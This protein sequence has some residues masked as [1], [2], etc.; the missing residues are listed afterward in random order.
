MRHHHADINTTTL[1]VSFM[2][3]TWKL[4]IEE[5]C[6][7]TT[8]TPEL[9]VHLVHLCLLRSRFHHLLP[10]ADDKK[11]KQS[12]E[13]QILFCDAKSVKSLCLYESHCWS[14]VTL[15]SSLARVTSFIWCDT[16]QAHKRIYTFGRKRRIS[17]SR[18]E[19]MYY[20]P[21]VPVGLFSQEH[22]I[23]D[24]QKDKEK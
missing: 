18:T 5:K 8:D 22:P 11:R 14:S 19:Q 12:L 10:E 1:T 21:E 20:I 4:N 2:V 7:E 13:N 6:M 17:T 9:Q 3:N 24:I 23:K 15:R 16:L